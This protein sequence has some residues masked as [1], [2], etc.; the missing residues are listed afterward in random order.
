MVNKTL[1]QD[2]GLKHPV[3]VLKFQLLCQEKRSVSSPSASEN[4]SILLQCQSLFP[5][6]R[7]PICILLKYCRYDVK[8]YSINQPI[9]AIFVV[10]T[11]KDTGDSGG[12]NS[13]RGKKNNNK[14]GTS[15]EQCFFSNR[16]KI[17]EENLNTKYSQVDDPL[18]REKKNPYTPSTIFPEN[19]HDDDM[20]RIATDRSTGPV[21]VLWTNSLTKLPVKTQH[22][23][24]RYPSP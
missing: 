12:W 6:T 18:C 14:P 8:H 16:E 23:D 24:H 1:N 20:N 15:T 5:W 22:R 4:A 17:K 2:N 7:L 10:G 21:E 9:W 11:L 13:S 3:R 19:V